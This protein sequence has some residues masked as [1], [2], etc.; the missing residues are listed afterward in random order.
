MCFSARAR[1]IADAL[2]LTATA[3]TP[4]LPAALLSLAAGALLVLPRPELARRWLPQA[5]AV[6]L[7]LLFLWAFTPWTTPGREWVSW[8]PFTVTHEGVMLS[9][10]VTV[11]SHAALLAWWALMGSLKLTELA[12]ALSALHVPDKLV[13]LLLLSSRQV[14][15]LLETYRHMRES[16]KLRAFE[17]GL[18]AHTYRTLAGWV[19]ALFIKA[20][21]RSRIMEDA[22]KLRGFEGVW[23]RHTPAPFTNA[24]RLLMAL[25]ALFAAAIAALSLI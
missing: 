6:S 20:F 24:D 3:L 19:S 14:D 11:K 22:L 15:C 2:W 5:R 25:A 1:L 18:N 21:D 13:T 16:A 23:P 10:L 9:L 12:R 8:G 7:F 17:P 4:S